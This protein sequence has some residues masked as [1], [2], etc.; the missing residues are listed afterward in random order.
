MASSC[1][2]TEEGGEEEEA[3]EDEEANETRSSNEVVDRPL[4]KC[5]ERCMPGTKDLAC[6]KAMKQNAR[7]R[8]ATAIFQLRPLKRERGQEGGGN[9]NFHGIKI[10][11]FPFDKQM[12]F[13]TEAS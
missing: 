3:S 8:L 10:I 4:K 2:L 12:N 9:P 11:K 7:R 5:K 6:G 13:L 1:S